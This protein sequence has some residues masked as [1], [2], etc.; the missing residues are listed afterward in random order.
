MISEGGFAEE[1]IFALTGIPVFRYSTVEGDTT[2]IQT[3]LAADLNN[4]IMGANT[5]AGGD[6]S[7][8]ICNIS[9]S[10]AYSLLAVFNITA[11]NGTKIPV[12]MIRNPWGTCGSSCYNG[13]LKSTDTFW[14]ASMIS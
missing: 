14:T 7:N 1:G 12:L 11:T 3:L 2:F 10:H 8:N 13:T 5:G 9:N 6:T 4:N